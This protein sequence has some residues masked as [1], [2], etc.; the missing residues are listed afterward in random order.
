[1]M[2]GHVAGH[3]CQASPTVPTVVMRCCLVPSAR[4]TYVSIW[5][6]RSLPNAILVP[7]GDHDG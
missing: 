4:I 3:G 2:G 5:P 7:S 1:M 6:L